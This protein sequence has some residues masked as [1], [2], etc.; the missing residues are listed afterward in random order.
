MWKGGVSIG[1]VTFPVSV[2]KATDDRQGIKLNILHSVCGQRIQEKKHCPEHGEIS[3]AE[4]VKGYE[5]SPGNFVQ[6]TETDL[7][8]IAIESERVLAIEQFV[9]A[10]SIGFAK[11]DYHLGT[12]KLGGPAYS[13]MRDAMR[14]QN[15]EAVV[16]VSFRSR[17]MLATIRPVGDMLMLTTHYWPDEVRSADGLVPDVAP[18]PAAEVAMASQLIAGMTGPFD[19]STQVDAYTN[20]LI[21]LIDDKSAGR[22]ITAPA[23]PAPVAVV[24]DLMATLQASL[25][26]QKE[27]KKRG[28]ASPAAA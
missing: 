3:A 27:P 11:G 1:M 13:L 22:A 5:I 2:Y 25:A 15:V 23:A 8:S 16:R 21:S 28:K 12:D 19:P 7:D 26:K 4:T 9:P 10:G 18:R 20:A 6:L 24:P 14:E 17:E